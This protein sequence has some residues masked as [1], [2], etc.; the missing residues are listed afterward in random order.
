M[1]ITR[2]INGTGRKPI[3]KYDF[4]NNLLKEYSYGKEILIDN[5][6]YSIGNIQA[7]CNGGRKKAY[8]FIWKYK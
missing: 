3:L 5:P 8:G 7:V 2:N 4:N 1:K 6:N